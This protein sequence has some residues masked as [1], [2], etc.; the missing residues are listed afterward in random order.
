M[1]KKSDFKVGQN[2]YRIISNRHTGDSVKKEVI[3]KIGIKYITLENKDRVSLIDLRSNNTHMS[4]QCYVDETTCLEI[5]V[6][7]ALIQD[8]R[9]SSDRYEL[10]KMSITKLIKIKEVLE[11]ED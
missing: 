3:N 8:I 1:Y 9:I 6:R 4:Y 5:I 2:L 10:K 11:S 7:D